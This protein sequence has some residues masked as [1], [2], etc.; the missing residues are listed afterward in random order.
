M[1][2]LGAMRGKDE[3]LVFNIAEYLN[4]A[5]K[6]GFIPAILDDAG[7]AHLGSPSPVV[8]IGLDKGKTKQRLEAQGVAIPRGFSALYANSP[9]L[10]MAPAAEIGYPLMVKPAFEGGHIGIDES[11]IVNNEEQLLSAIGRIFRFYHQDAIVESF[12]GG[13][14][15]REFSVGV[16]DGDDRR[17]ILPIEIDYDSMQT[18][19]RIL[20]FKTAQAD[21]ERIKPVKDE[22][23]KSRLE[24]IASKAFD[25]LGARDYARIDLRMNERECYVLE[26]NLMPGLG[27]HSFLPEAARDLVGIEYGDLVRKL[28]RT[29]ISREYGAKP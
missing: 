7:Y 2:K 9:N 14:G 27:P 10:A 5:T 1:N 4:E 25:A 20:S 13:P 23:L 8:G 12:I 3:L 26:A 19:I 21:L 6:Q 15:M 18:D 17:I 24:A 11:S 28:A 22:R 16:V 29:A